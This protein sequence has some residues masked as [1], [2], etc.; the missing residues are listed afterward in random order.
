[1]PIRKIVEIDEEKCDGCGLCVDVCHEGAIQLVDGKAR[2]I[3]DILCDG[4]GDCLGE[5]P[6]GAITITEREAEEY[7]Q[8]A[9]DEHRTPKNPASPALPMVGGCPGSASRQLH[10]ATTPAT[11]GAPQP[12]QLR[13]WPV[14]LHLAPVQAPYFDGA[15]LLIAADCVPFAHGDFHNGLLAGRTLLIGCPKLDDTSAYL[16]KLS[17]IFR[18]NAL[19]SVEVAY[20]EVP[21]CRGLVMLVQKA[22]EA[23]GKA[24]T[25]RP[26]VTRIGIRGELQETTRTE[27]RERAATSAGRAR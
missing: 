25:L 1:M 6:Q 16:E 12:S 8:Q 24:D 7:S 13:N 11:S 15:K 14:Q 22:I 20:M 18:F 3:S 23:A 10:P 4:F 26:T 21:C 5:C 17:A 19:S 27:P 9:V 2:L